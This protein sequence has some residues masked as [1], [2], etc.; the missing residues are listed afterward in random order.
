MLA[1]IPV[2]L[3]ACL[4]LLVPGSALGQT[5]TITLTSLTMLENQQL[6]KPTNTPRKGDKIEF[7]D[8]LLN[9]GRA[10]FGRHNGRAVAWDEGIVRYTSATET[11]ILVLATFPGLGTIT[12]QGPLRADRN[13]NSVVPI[14]HGT[15]VF[16]GARGTVTIGRGAESAPNTFKVTVP[17]HPIDLTSPGGAA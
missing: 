5:V 3:C 8:L 6:L 4:A 1:R 7:R 17:G 11:S 12:Y 16:K 10:Q 15:G 9:R 14:V 13:G 2:L